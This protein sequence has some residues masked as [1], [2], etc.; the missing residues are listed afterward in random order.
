MKIH[1]EKLSKFEFLLSRHNKTILL[2]ENPEKLKFELRL[3]IFWPC[4]QTQLLYFEMK[5]LKSSLVDYLAQGCILL[6]YLSVTSSKFIQKF[7][8]KC[9]Y[10]TLIDWCVS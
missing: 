2:T 10:F 7:A 6:N 1:Q 3:E 9:Q 8:Q 4:L 5:I